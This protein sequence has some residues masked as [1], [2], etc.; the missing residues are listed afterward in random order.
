LTCII[1]LVAGIF[2]CS[3]RHPAKIDDASIAISGPD[4]VSVGEAVTVTAE[5]EG[6]DSW[7]WALPTGTHRV[8]DVE[9]TMTP[10]EQ[11]T[12]EIILRGRADDGEELEARHH[13]TVTE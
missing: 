3:D 7:I 5:S 1:D 10:T 11:G 9:A 8:D 12:N 4:E 6:V 13:V 2:V